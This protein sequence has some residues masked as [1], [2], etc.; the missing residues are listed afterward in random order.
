MILNEFNV[1]LMILISQ[2]NGRLLKKK[3]YLIFIKDF[4][5]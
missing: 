2:T 4:I 3:Y 1:I 5:I